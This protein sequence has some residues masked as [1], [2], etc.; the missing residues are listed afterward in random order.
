MCRVQR[1][2]GKLIYIPNPFRT[3][4]ISGAHKPAGNR[5]ESGVEERPS[6]S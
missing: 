4:F 5:Q 1:Q 3:S 6:V 2:S